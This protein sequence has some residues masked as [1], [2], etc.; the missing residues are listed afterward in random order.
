MCDPEKSQPFYSVWISNLEHFQI[1]PFFWKF[2]PP[3]NCARCQSVWQCVQ[4]FF[5]YTCI[6]GWL[7]D[8]VILGVT[9]CLFAFVSIHETNVCQWAW[10]FVFAC[11]CS[12]S[13]FFWGVLLL[14]VFSVQINFSTSSYFNLNIEFQCIQWRKSEKE[15]THIDDDVEGKQEREQ[16][17]IYESHSMFQPNSCSS[18]C[19]LVF[20]SSSVFSMP[21]TDAVWRL[22]KKKALHTS[23]TCVYCKC[24]T[25]QLA[26]Y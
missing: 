7:V 14:S 8:F 18:R 25:F 9:K 20:S 10:L 1:R 12:I 21:Y 5:E 4:I 17:F 15:K 24:I 22:K 6:L 13:L 23:T 2:P 3:R 26:P 16:K 19:R 11:M